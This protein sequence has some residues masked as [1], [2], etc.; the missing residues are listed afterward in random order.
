M[1]RLLALRAL[2]DAVI[3][4]PADLRAEVA[5]WL[6]LEVVKP[7]GHDPHPPIVSSSPRPA[8][9]R[10]AAPAGPLS[11]PEKRLL[12]T[13]RNHPGASGNELSK[14]AG[15]ARSTMGARLKQL[16]A[17]GKIEK[18]PDGKWKL[19][20]EEPRP[21]AQSEEARSTSPPSN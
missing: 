10:P 11:A 5:R 17:R 19:K 15:A 7:N 6:T 12:A 18:G 20:G 2:I 9:A 3:A 14:L 13:V 16:E 8:K 21:P 4:L 1:D